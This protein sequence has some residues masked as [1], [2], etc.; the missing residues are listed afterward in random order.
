MPFYQRGLAFFARLTRLAKAGYAIIARWAG[1]PAAPPSPAAAR[2]QQ[3]KIDLDRTVHGL[4][5]AKSALLDHFAVATLHGDFRTPVPC[6]V[7]PPSV[8]KRALIRAFTG[9]LNRSMRSLDLRKLQSAADQKPIAGQFNPALG[10]VVESMQEAAAAGSALLFENVD[11]LRGSGDP[12]WFAAALGQPNEEQSRHWQNLGLQIPHLGQMLFV[13]TARDFSAIPE[14]IRGYFIEVRVPGY[15]PEEKVSILKE[16]MLAE[17]ISEVGLARRDIRVST[18]DLLYFARMHTRDAG[19]EEIRALLLPLLRRC[20]YKRIATGGRRQR[21]T[22]EMLDEVPWTPPRV[23]DERTSSPE[24]G[25]VRQLTATSSGG[26]I[27]AVEAVSFPGEGRLM[28]TGGR[29][30]S[31]QDAVATAFSYVRS[32]AGG[33]GIADSAFSGFDVHVHFPFGVQPLKDS[34]GGV[35]ACLAIASTLAGR[36]IRPESVVSGELTLHGRILEAKHL[37]E[38]VLAA[39]RADVKEVLLPAASRRAFAALPETLTSGLNV[40]MVEHI[41]DVFEIALLS[42]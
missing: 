1:R 27:I 36:T 34:P 39:C 21:I 4:T 5:Q 11:A 41:T 33:L 14:E 35:A 10:R 29:A 28:L 38:Q 15:T 25:I 6:L 3:V 20:A 42:R 30:D 37:H 32:H 8:G 22:R 31:T 13:A 24:I 19:M 2:L 18:D 9:S 40:H 17:M 12:G 23:Y 16:F 26:E 7:G